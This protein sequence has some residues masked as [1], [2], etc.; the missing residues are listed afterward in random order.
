MSSTESGDSPDEQKKAPPKIPIPPKPGSVSAAGSPAT[1][2]PPSTPTS[3]PTGAVPTSSIP[4]APRPGGFVPMAPRPMGAAPAPPRPPS[5][6]AVAQAPPTKPNM[7]EELWDYII[8]RFERT[9]FFGLKFTFPKKFVSPLGF[10]G[11][12]T[13]MVFLL[14]GITGGLLMIY[15]EPTLPGC[16]SFSCAFS[17]VSNIT[18]SVPYGWFIRDIHY[19][20]SNAMV[21]LAALHLYY[22]YFSGRFKIKNEV[23]WVT[24]M[25]FGLI[26]VLEAFTGYDII[27]N[28]RAGLAI[29]IGA[30]LANSSPSIGPVTGSAIRLATFGSGFSDFI[31]R[32]FA[33]HVFILPMVMILLTF[34]HF[35]RYLVFDLP[36]VASVMGGIFV[37]GA[38]FP[39]QLGTAYSP[40]NGQLTIP[41]WYL[42]SLYALLRTELDK[43][44]M[45]GLIPV[46]LLLMFAV[47]PFV[48]TSKKMS[49]KERPFFAALGI[50]SIG[51]VLATTSWGAYVNPDTSLSTLARLYVDPTLYFGSMLVLTA[52]S[53]ALTY[54]VIN[55]LNSKERVRKALQPMSLSFLSREWLTAILFLLIAVQVIMNAFAVQAVASGFNSIA[56]F[57]LG[58][59]FITFSVIVHLYRYSQQL[60]F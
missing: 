37:I 2:A 31:L 40:G 59:I 17:S 12:L 53:F 26:T 30:S 49:W 32:L 38:L 50:T 3:P 39:V 23:I 22:Q 20:A 7:I 42:T 60:P 44:T 16:G 51:Q 41:E 43:F 9:V 21:L 54:A 56:L 10:L 28:Q 58:V 14:L 36:V 35:P 19:T 11:V 33:A 8:N 15:Y 45:A 1:V 48:D 27:F 34:F 13:G 6:P 25:I 4:P 18:N 55:F 57:E 5:A 47:V 24:G 46:L 29:E 52:V